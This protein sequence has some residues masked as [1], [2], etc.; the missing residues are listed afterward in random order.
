MQFDWEG[1]KSAIQKNPEG[2]EKLTGRY[3]LTE[4]GIEFVNAGQP[5]PMGAV[6]IPSL[7]DA[8]KVTDK[9]LGEDELSELL[10]RYFLQQLQNNA[11]GKMPSHT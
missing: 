6:Q 11:I 9:K 8:Y 10:A 3:C 1:L 5:K 4:K 7:A 2:H